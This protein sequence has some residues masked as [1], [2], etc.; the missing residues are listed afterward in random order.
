MAVSIQATDNTSRVLIDSRTCLAM[1]TRSRLG[2]HIMSGRIATTATLTN[3]SRGTGLP[4]TQRRQQVRQQVR[5][6]NLL[7]CGCCTFSSH[8]QLMQRIFDN[9]WLL[10]SSMG[11]DNQASSVDASRTRIG[12][13]FLQQKSCRFFS[14]K[15]RKRGGKRERTPNPFIQPRRP[16]EQDIGT[17]HSVPDQGKEKQLALLQN[18]VQ[19]AYREGSYRSGLKHAQTY[20]KEAHKHFGDHH[21]ATACAHNDVGLFGKLLGDFDLARFSYKHALKI[22]KKIVGA[23]HANYATQLHNLGTL[24]RTQV[25]LDTMIKATDRLTLLEEA[26]EVSEKAYRIRLDERGPDHPHTVASRSSWGAAL[27]MQILQNYKQTAEN[28][29]RQ[30]SIPTTDVTRIAATVAA[31]NAAEEHLRKALQTAIDKP[32]GPSLQ[33]AKAQ[34]AMDASSSAKS[35]SI[36][37]LKAELLSSNIQTLS[38]SAAAQNLAIFLK[39]RATTVERK[40]KKGKE[41][42]GNDTTTENEKEDKVLVESTGKDASTTAKSSKKTSDGESEKA[43]EVADINAATSLT[44][45]AASTLS[46]EKNE[47]N[48]SIT[49]TSSSSDSDTVSEE[50]EEDPTAQA[51]AWFQEAYSLYQDVLAVRQELL[52]EG[53]PDLYATKHSLAELLQAMGKGDEANKIRD[54]IVDTYDPPSPQQP[55]SSSSNTAT[56]TAPMGEAEASTTAKSMTGGLETKKDEQEQEQGDKR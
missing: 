12:T 22:Y 19:D 23:D 43:L 40:D 39:A 35:T 42:G 28:Q 45:K 16:G 17:K 5:H 38:A 25:H 44:E 7:A 52:P 41:D 32:R 6:Q 31:W 3:P 50:E 47:P 18:K 21:P 4:L 51:G 46:E 54:E 10:A 34:K 9:P 33:Q 26:I 20:L 13:P 55:Q 8:S 36:S 37:T 15:S 11:N 56:A 49:T 30:V 53:H 24:N 2:P 48:N 29:Y 14:K 27:A 1:W